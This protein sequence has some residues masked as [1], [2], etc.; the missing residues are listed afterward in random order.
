M[1]L[2]VAGPTIKDSDGTNVIIIVIV[3]LII[4]ATIGIIVS[5]MK[6]GKKNEKK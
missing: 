5:L 1:I 2:D 6:R 3:I 4:L